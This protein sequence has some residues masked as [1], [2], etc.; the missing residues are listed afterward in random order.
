MATVTTRVNKDKDKLTLAALSE[1]RTGCGMML[2]NAG[3]QSKA[4][5]CA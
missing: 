5:V 2:R 4:C 3:M 1:A